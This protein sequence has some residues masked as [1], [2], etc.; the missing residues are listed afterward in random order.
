MR[1][2]V[3]LRAVVTLRSNSQAAIV[4]KTHTDRGRD[5]GPLQR[6]SYAADGREES[7]H[8]ADLSLQSKVERLLAKWAL[9]EA[10]ASETLTAICAHIE[11]PGVSCAL[12]TTRAHGKVETLAAA[13]T[14]GDAQ[15][16]SRVAERCTSSRALVSPHDALWSEVGVPDALT[17]AVWLIHE[18]LVGHDEAPLG[19]MVVIGRNGASCDDVLQAVPECARA[20]RAVLARDR[21]SIAAADLTHTLANLLAAVICNVE[22]AADLLEVAD[23][24]A[25][26]RDELVQA[27]ENACQSAK[28]VITMGDAILAL[29]RAP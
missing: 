12:V 19:S 23:V 7:V 11:R 9:G 13:N 25:E 4:T 18:P 14:C 20:C 3:R 24:G 2:V 6:T 27:M 1:A 16:S 15:L 21:I 10:S 8:P 26:H 28:Q 29:T 17:D 5:Q 22:Y